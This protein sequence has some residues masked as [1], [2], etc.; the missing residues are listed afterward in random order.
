M[1][2]RILKRMHV[3]PSMQR[4]IQFERL[5]RA[6]YMEDESQELDI[7]NASVSQPPE[8]PTNDVESSQQ[9]FTV[10]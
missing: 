10:S 3:Y 2:D 4:A 5:R 6:E 7:D 1:V 9:L 8:A